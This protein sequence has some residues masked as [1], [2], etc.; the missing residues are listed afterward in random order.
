[1]LLSLRWVAERLFSDDRYANYRS[2][3]ELKHICDK[4]PTMAHEML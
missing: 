3:T 1:M 4:T 2:G